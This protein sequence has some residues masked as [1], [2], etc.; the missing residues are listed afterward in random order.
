MAATPT[1]HCARDVRENNVYIVPIGSVRQSGGAAVW[2][3][4]EVSAGQPMAIASVLCSERDRRTT[5]KCLARTVILEN[6]ER[7]Q[8]FLARGEI[9]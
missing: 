8:E 4:A 9:F 1:M 7:L 3:L 6:C 5:S 2:P